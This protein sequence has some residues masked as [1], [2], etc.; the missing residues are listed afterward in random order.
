VLERLDLGELFEQTPEDRAPANLE[1]R[2]R[3]VE[4][5]RIEPGGVPGGENDPVQR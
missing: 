1:Q 2:L 3:L 4:R 5:E